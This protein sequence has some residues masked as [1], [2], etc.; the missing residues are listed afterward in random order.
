MGTASSVA[1]FF[2]LRT[3]YASRYIWRSIVKPLEFSILDREKRTPGMNWP[4]PS[5]APW[6]ASRALSTS[7]CRKRFAT[8]IN[9]L[10]KRRSRSCDPRAISRRLRRSVKLCAITCRIIWFRRRRWGKRQAKAGGAN[11][12][13][14]RQIAW[15]GCVTF[16]RCA[17][18]ARNSQKLAVGGGKGAGISARKVGQEL[19]MDQCPIDDQI[20][21]HHPQTR[22]DLGVFQGSL[23]VK[24]SS[25][26]EGDAVRH[27]PTVALAHD[28]AHLV[29]YRQSFF[30][31]GTNIAEDFAGALFPVVVEEVFHRAGHGSVIVRRRK[32]NGR[33]P[34]HV[35]PQPALGRGAAGVIR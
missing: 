35:R 33:S 30:V 29:H 24:I 3:P 23:G 27:T 26:I 19:L 21:G 4:A 13:E 1:I 7:K 20:A 25:A 16:M 9:I 10:R 14:L 5:S 28:R 34:L 32:H 22:F 17:R 12:C 15:L 8:N 18:R 31:R 11:R 2:T 6:A